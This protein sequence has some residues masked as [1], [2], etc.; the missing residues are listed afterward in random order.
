[1][2]GDEGRREM[3]EEKNNKSLRRL[4]L[5]ELEILKYFID[6][7]DRNDLR[8]YIS[9]GTFLGAVRHKGFI[10]WDDDVDIAMPRE[11]YEVFLKNSREVR[12]KYVISTFEDDSETV[13]YQT[14]IIDT[15][16]KVR[17][18]SGKKEQT[19]SAWV[20][21]FPLDGMPK[22]RVLSKIHQFRLMYLRAKLKFACFDQVNMNEKNRPLTERFLIKMGLLFPFLRFNNSLKYLNKI[23]RC[24]KKYPS[25]DSS[26]FIN[27][28][29]AYKLKS[30]LDKKYYYGD[31]AYYSFEGLRLF[32]PSNYDAYLSHFYGDYMKV[33]PVHERNKHNTEVIED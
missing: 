19:W 24:L 29:G 32:G 23:D 21:V 17:N 1:M 27:F 2:G 25:K 5:C 20:D 16:V 3:T 9:G 11:D 28:M 33:P 14:K 12:F 18:T 4:Q 15:S 13:H 10:P 31:G 7:C 30:I 26:V 22:N 6:Y 8:Y